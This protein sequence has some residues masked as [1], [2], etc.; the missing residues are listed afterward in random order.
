MRTFVS[1]FRRRLEKHDKLEEKI[2]N[3]LRIVS[4]RKHL[5]DRWISIGDKVCAIDVKTSIYVEDNSHDEYFRV[6][7]E[8]TPVII[9]YELNGVIRANWI[10]N[11]QWNGPYPPTPNST[12]GD[13]Y[14]MISGGVPI[15]EFLVQAYEQFGK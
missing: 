9:A 15:Y 6:L 2:M 3:I 7:S 10:Q 13:H 12:C 1:L 4:H 8:G 11:L 5:P 14:Y